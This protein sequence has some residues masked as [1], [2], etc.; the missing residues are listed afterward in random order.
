MALQSFRASIR[1][2]ASTRL[3][4]GSSEAILAHAAYPPNAHIKNAFRK[5]ACAAFRLCGRLALND[6]KIKAPPQRSSRQ[7]STLVRDQGLEP[8]TP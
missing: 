7:N 1:R 4:A 6:C 3:K 8:W 5:Q 2:I